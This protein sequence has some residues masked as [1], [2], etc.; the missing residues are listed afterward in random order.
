MHFLNS[1]ADGFLLPFES[2]ARVSGYLDGIGRRIAD[3][4]WTH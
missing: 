2:V 1:F 3:W 4:L